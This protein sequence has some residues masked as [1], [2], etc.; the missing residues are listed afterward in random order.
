MK[1]FTG[2]G[3]A[4]VISIVLFGVYRTFASLYGFGY[5]DGT[6]ASDAAHGKVESELREQIAAQTATA[7][8]ALFLT[9][10]NYLSEKPKEEK[11]SVC[12]NAQAPQPGSIK[13]EPSFLGHRSWCSDGETQVSFPITFSSDGWPTLKEPTVTPAV[14][15]IAL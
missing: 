5:E 14:H 15:T 6:A 12:V 3:I 10:R 11:V 2:I 7:E 1:F 9:N 8:A 4:A 13:V